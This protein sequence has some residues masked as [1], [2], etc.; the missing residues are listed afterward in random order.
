MDYNSVSK[1]NVHI[2]AENHGLYIIQSMV[3]CQNLNINFEKNLGTWVGM[4][5]S[6]RASQEEQNDTNFSFILLPLR[7]S[8]R[9]YPYL[10]ILT[11]AKKRKKRCHQKEQLKRSLKSM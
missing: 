9:W 5:S 8:F 3:F 7:C 6:E 10:Q 2:L 1:I 4:I 11:L